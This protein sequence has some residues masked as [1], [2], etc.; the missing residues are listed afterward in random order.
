MEKVYKMKKEI[1]FQKSSRNSKI[2]FPYTY[3]PKTY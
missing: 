1:D 3:N 2:F